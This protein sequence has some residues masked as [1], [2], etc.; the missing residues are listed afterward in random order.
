MPP[1]SLITMLPFIVVTLFSSQVKFTHSTGVLFFTTIIVSLLSF[2][3]SPFHLFQIIPMQNNSCEFNKQESC[4]VVKCFQYNPKMFKF[5]PSI[6][7][8]LPGGR[9][10]NKLQGKNCS[11]YI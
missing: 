6:M 11:L 8:Y 10:G 4:M 1:W 5:S 3:T 9:L 2:L 7:T